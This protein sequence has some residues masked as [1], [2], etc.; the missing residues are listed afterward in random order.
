M[1]AFH[2]CAQLLSPC[3]A[4]DCTYE[5]GCTIDQTP[6]TYTDLSILIEHNSCSVYI[7][8]HTVVSRF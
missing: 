1:Q 3:Q 5:D 8:I 7:F 2:L 4:G 6:F